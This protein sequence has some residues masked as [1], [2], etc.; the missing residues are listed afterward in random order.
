MN[1]IIILRKIR[2]ILIVLAMFGGLG[3][4]I[5][6]LINNK[7]AVHS[8]LNSKELSS[9]P[10]M[11]T[12]RYIKPKPI[13]EG[14][15]RSNN[16][17]YQPGLIQ[18]RLDIP[19]FIRRNLAKV[20]GNF[21]SDVNVNNL[22][23]AKE[24]TL[25]NFFGKENPVVQIEFAKPQYISGFSLVTAGNNPGRF[26]VEAIVER[27][28]G[29]GNI[30][31][32]REQLGEEGEFS[33]GR[34]C[35]NQLKVPVP[36]RSLRLVLQK[37]NPEKNVSI[38]G[39]DIYGIVQITNVRISSS[40]RLIRLYKTVECALQIQDSNG[41]FLD[42][43]K[44][45]RWTSS[46]PLVAQVDDKGIIRGFKEGK[47]II[48]VD[49][50][51]IKS[52]P[53][54]FKVFLPKDTPT[55]IVAT[56]MHKKVYLEWVPTT[57]KFLSHYRVYRRT[58]KGEFTEKYIGKTFTNSFTDQGLTPGQTYYYRVQAYDLVGDKIASPSEEIA[59]T[60]SKEKAIYSTIPTTEILVLLYREGMNDYMVKQRKRGLDE[61]KLFYYR[62]TKGR[63]LFDMTYYEIYAYPPE[64]ADPDPDHPT[65]AHIARDCLKRG[66]EDGQF[67]IIYATGQGLCG[68]WGG[69]GI[70]GGR[71]AFGDAA[72]VPYPTRDKEIDRAMIW[73]FAH[74]CH[75]AFDGVCDTAGKT[76]M[77]GCHFYDNFP[78]NTNI[79]LDAGC[80][81]DGIANI[82][83][84][85]PSYEL[86]EPFKQE[87]EFLDFDQD[88]FPDRDP[89]F[90][91]DEERFGSRPDMKDTDGD[92]LSDI[93]E[94]YAGNFTGTDP[95]NFDTDGDGIPDGKDK[96]P[97]YNV[98]EVV[99]YYPS[100]HKIDGILEPG[101][102]KFSEGII[103]HNDTT[104]KVRTY[105][106]YNDDYLFIAFES[107]KRLK[108][109]IEID[110]SGEDG[111]WSSPYK[112]EG[113][114]NTNG[115][116]S[117]SDSYVED[118]A[119]MVEDGKKYIVC[120]G[121]RLDFD[122]EKKSKDNKTQ[123]NNEI[124][125]AEVAS[126]VKNNKYSSG[127][128]HIIE[129]KIPRKLPPGSAWTYFSNKAKVIDGL[130]LKPGNII[131]I[132]FYV[133]V[134]GDYG[135][136]QFAGVWG[137]VFET[138]HFVDVSLGDAK[139]MDGDG[140]DAYT[141][142]ARGTDP[143]IADT[144]GDGIPDGQDAQPTINLLR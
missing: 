140:L 70:L 17:Q 133:G 30:T 79:P 10:A 20:T 28:D 19:Q 36:C 38:I 94:F 39:W 139:D 75:H 127:Y 24:T 129:V 44:D 22:F 117:M 73:S 135:D 92:G 88:G 69:F 16:G 9:R 91:M 55:G 72:N 114:D 122:T 124:A 50:Y 25:L 8:W 95:N 41:L 144:D 130:Q 37:S 71:G 141:E 54:D 59:V 65:M 34:L 62:N 138:Y 3:Y 12:S 11:K 76:P 80:H 90:P 104:L 84:N 81:Y 142:S 61:A 1:Y 63:L 101:W 66:V 112:F 29:F 97:L 33:S 119:F 46:E 110:G 111:R 15:Y 21:P 132:N 7:D 123:R 42:N 134:Q 89:R 31:K 77:Y 58:E 78:L 108:A 56:P 120:K 43:L 125:G 13:E 126:G 4:G 128:G 86:R 2:R 52:N 26:I 64:T 100:G 143:L 106:N 51:G 67:D 27:K 105:M 32:T 45:V 115:K 131:G 82:L 93:E 107:N 83:R 23:D 40:E 14:L 85:Y 53:L 47:A 103:F 98:S 109:F 118:A 137:N 6:W 96:Y 18:A 87:I 74:E 60:T 48:A 5:Y 49:A 116:L 35:V 102:S 136:S 121:E 99:P 113:S 68:C 57:N